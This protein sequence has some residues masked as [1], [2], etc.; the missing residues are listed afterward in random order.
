MGGLLLVRA[1]VAGYAN[2]R[3]CEECDVCASGSGPACLRACGRRRGRRGFAARVPPGRAWSVWSSGGGE[4]GGGGGDANAGVQASTVGGW[5]RALP[6]RRYSGPRA[7]CARAA[8][9]RSLSRGVTTPHAGVREY[10][11]GGRRGARRK[12]R[13]RKGRA[14]E[15]VEVGGGLEPGRPR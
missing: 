10:L 3:V 8:A 5:V 7:A 13:K 6:F 1:M 2:V 11:R 15:W 4:C 14:E 9:R 12:R